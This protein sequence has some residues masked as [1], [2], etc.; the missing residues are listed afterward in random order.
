MAFHT[1]RRS[2]VI[3]I[4]QIPPEESEVQF[5]CQPFCSLGS[6]YPRATLNML[7]DYGW[8]DHII[9]CVEGFCEPCQKFLS[10][11]A[12]Q[13]LPKYPKHTLYD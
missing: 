12:L 8:L 2:G 3:W 11:I 10:H 1:V 7:R 6:G 9:I 4:A 5:W 13:K